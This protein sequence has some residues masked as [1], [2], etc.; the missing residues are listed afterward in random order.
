[1]LLGGVHSRGVVWRGHRDCVD[2]RVCH[3]LHGKGL[4][5][6]TVTKVA[7][8]TVA[9]VLA[10]GLSG[11]ESCSRSYKSMQSDFGG[12]L[13]RKVT[14]Y[15]YDGEV[16][17]QWEGTFDVAEDNQECWFDI[18]GRRVIIQGGIVVNEEIAE[19]DGD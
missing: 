18:D 9:S 3:R 13:H 16:L 11:C 15:D 10:M 7:A 4:D 12:G 2:A 5:M 8:L 19:E 6:S 14:L 1:M 17:G